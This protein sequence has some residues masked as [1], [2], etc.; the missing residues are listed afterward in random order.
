MEAI[1]L[2]LFPFEVP[3]IGFRD[4]ESLEVCESDAEAVLIVTSNGENPEPVEVTAVL[5]NQL[6]HVSWY[7]STPC[8]LSSSAKNLPP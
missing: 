6:R 3:S 4:V 7:H 5:A 2:S 1:S 8:L